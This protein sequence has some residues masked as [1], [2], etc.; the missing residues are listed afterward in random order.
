MGTL[1]IPSIYFVCLSVDMFVSNKRQNRRTDRAQILCGTSH[2]PR[3]GFWII[4]ISKN[5]P[6]QNLMI[7]T[8]EMNEKVLIF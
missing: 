6:Q 5:S 4:K 1:Y 2:N 7:Y 3:E 8:Q